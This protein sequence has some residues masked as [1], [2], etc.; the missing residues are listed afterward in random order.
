[1]GKMAKLKWPMMAAL[2]ALTFAAGCN[3]NGPKPT[4]CVGD[5]PAAPRIH[6]VAPPNCP[7]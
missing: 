7:N 4:A 2:V 6:D 1:M 3:R 5:L